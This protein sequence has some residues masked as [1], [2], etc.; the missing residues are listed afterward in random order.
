MFPKSENG[1][2]SLRENVSAHANRATSRFVSPN[3]CCSLQAVLL[4]SFKIKNLSKC[5]TSCL[6]LFFSTKFVSLLKLN[7]ALSATLAI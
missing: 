7:L 4:L 1:H 5:F 2:I 6:D 3:H